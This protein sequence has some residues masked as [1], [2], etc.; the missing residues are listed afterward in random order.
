MLGTILRLAFRAGQMLMDP[1]ENT[2]AGTPMSAIVRTIEINLLEQL[3]ESDLPE[4]VAPINGRYV[5]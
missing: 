2:P 1:F 4:P 3:G 5:L